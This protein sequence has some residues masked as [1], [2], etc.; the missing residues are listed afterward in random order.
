[1]VP[2]SEAMIGTQIQKMHWNKRGERENLMGKI[3]PSRYNVCKKK[4]S[5]LLGNYVLHSKMTVQR[6]ELV[7]SEGLGEDVCSFFFVEGNIGR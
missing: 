1:M 5:Q 7:L 2:R 3:C 4:N 6:M